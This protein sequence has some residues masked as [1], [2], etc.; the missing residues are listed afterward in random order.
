MKKYLLLHGFVEYED[1]YSAIHNICRGEDG[2]RYEFVVRDFEP[3]FYALTEI[4]HEKVVKTEKSEL[5]SY[6]GNEL[7]KI[8]TER[9][10]DVPKVRNEVNFHYEADIPFPKRFLYDKG[11]YGFF[12]LPGD[13]EFEIRDEKMNEI[14]VPHEHFKAIETADIQP[15]IWCVDIETLDDVDAKRAKNPIVSIGVYDENKDR[16]AVFIVTKDKGNK[17]RVDKL[18]KDNFGEDIT[19][20]TVIRCETEQ[21]MLQKFNQSLARVQPDIMYGWNFTD[22]DITFIKNRMKK[23]NMEL[24]KRVM[25][26]DAEGGYKKLSENELPSTKLDEIAR[27]EFDQKKIPRESIR[28]MLENDPDKLIAY[29]IGDVYLTSKINHKRNVVNFHL[30]LAKIAGTDLCSTPHNSMLGDSFFLHMSNG[31]TILPSGRIRRVRTIDAGGK[32]QDAY[33][34]IAK[35]VVGFDLNKAYPTAMEECNLS[36]ETKLGFMCDNCKN[37]CKKKHI[38][39]K[40][41]S[42]GEVSSHDCEKWDPKEKCIKVP[43]GRCYTTDFIGM[44]PRAV[45]H[46]MKLR[47]GF[48]KK[49][50]ECLAAGDTV[51]EKTNF[52]MQ[53]GTKKIVNSLYGILGHIEKD[54]KD[55]PM[56][57]A[58]FRLADGEIGSDVTHIIRLLINWIK[59]HVEDLSK[60]LKYCKDEEEISKL[61]TLMKYQNVIK[62]VYGDTDSCIFTIPFIEL[63]ENGYDKEQVIE[64]CVFIEELLNRSS[65]D[66]AKTHTGV[67]AFYGIEFEKFYESFFQG[68]KKKKYAG[69]YLWKKG[70]WMNERSYE[71]RKEIRGY[72]VRRSDWSPLCKGLM[73]KTFKHLIVDNMTE[74]EFGRL[75]RVWK[76]EFFAGQY[77][78][79]IKWAKRI[80]VWTGPNDTDKNGRQKSPTMQQRAAMKSNEVFGT[81]WK[82]G[83]KPY[84]CYMNKLKNGEKYDVIAMDIDDDPSDFGEIDYHTMWDN[85]VRGPLSRIVEALG[86]DWDYIESGSKQVTGSAFF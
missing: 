72:E 69:F 53:F 24:D 52:E 63:L 60:L 38:V 3:Y 41:N 40:K 70:S 68:G 4:D 42:D 22:F 6:D 81:A 30:S 79:E 7:Y 2:K 10:G 55:S 50:K 12:E 80:G 74:K 76:K 19:N 47:K 39:I 17:G 65:T 16:Y 28:E 35:Y 20:Y 59:I 26:F 86:W 57:T 46:L 75:V 13:V 71:E 9:S 58:K 5:H 27:V 84:M 18:L 36:P 54:Y 78:R 67:E 33:K 34:G 64:L 62:K 11:I 85:Q 14:V 44:I 21:E 83:D 37:D 15:H 49:E 48:Q 82:E 8:Y 45:G 61:K 29:N 66:F 31:H 25:N 23:Y 77:D 1:E 32:V 73:N 43:S 56:G 51:N